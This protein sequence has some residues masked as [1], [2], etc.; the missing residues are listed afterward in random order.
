MD[1]D[2]PNSRSLRILRPEFH[3]ITNPCRIKRIPL[4]SNLCLSRVIPYN[5]VAVHMICEYV[6]MHFPLRNASERMCATLRWW[7]RRYFRPCLCFALLQSLTHSH[8][9][10]SYRISCF[11]L[12]CFALLGWF[13]SV[14]SKGPSNVDAMLLQTAL[15]CSF[16]PCATTAATTTTLTTTRDRYY[17]TRWMKSEKKGMMNFAL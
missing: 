5:G 10:H 7:R 4:I 13:A 8:L 6:S 11:C 12:L 16:A 1:L 9:H 15:L 2:K 3:F 14:T 17:D